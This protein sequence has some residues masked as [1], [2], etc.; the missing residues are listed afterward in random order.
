MPTEAQMS[1]IQPIRSDF[2]AG[3]QIKFIVV[4]AIGALL[5]TLAMY[6][7]LDQGLGSNYFDALVTLSTV[8]EALTSSLVITFCLQLFL[9]FVLTIGL[10]LFVSHKI[11]GPVFRYEDCL[12]KIMDGDLTMNVRTRDGDQLKSL[13]ESM[14]L[15]QNS[16]RD[17][18]SQA[19][20]LERELLSQVSRAGT[21][22]ESETT[23]LKQ[24]LQAMHQVLAI[25]S[26]DG[27]G[28]HE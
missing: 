22:T 18:Y 9:I 11:A 26:V 19:H 2:T 25:D 8:E 17:V 20:Q 24:S 3:F 28:N 6:F 7:Y 14:N 21:T 5:T 1:G 4:M 16:L 10:T 15:W 27:G 13:V 12:S 23:E